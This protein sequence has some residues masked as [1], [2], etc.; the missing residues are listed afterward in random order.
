MRLTTVCKICGQDLVSD[1]QPDQPAATIHPTCDTRPAGDRHRPHPAEGHLVAAAHDL[2]L[3]LA[4]AQA[5]PD[6]SP[7]WAAFDQQAT[8]VEQIQRNNLHVDLGKAA[9]YYVTR[10]GWPVFPLKPGDKAPLTRHGFKDATLDPG[11]VAE[12]WQAT[13][14]ANIGIPTGVAFDVIDVDTPIHR[15]QF[16]AI[17]DNPNSDIH[18]IA[19][20]S[21]SGWHLLIPPWEGPNNPGNQ[22]KAF[23]E[24]ID[25]RTHGGYIV[26]PWSRRP[27]RRY[28]S[29]YS[30]PSTQITRGR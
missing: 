28:W 8:I 29:W 5:T 22:V 18:G 2:T 12:W 25:Y 26:A 3:L 11:Q 9:H 14:E 13:P 20:T 10:L 24:G 17:V 15:T 4:E 21:S 7:Q 16:D 19:S 27:G 23:G 30:N 1:W 6:G